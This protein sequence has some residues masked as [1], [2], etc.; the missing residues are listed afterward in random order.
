MIIQNILPVISDWKTFEAFLKGSYT[1]CI[2]MDF[3][4]NFMEDLVKQLH[5]HNKKGIV[6]MDL[7]HGIANDQYGT[8]YM[9]QKVHADG[10]ISTKPKAIEAAKSNQ[11]ISILRIFMID[12]R[13]FMRSVH[14]ASA[15]QPDY[16]EVL[17][18]LL[19]GIVKKL[20]AY[21]DIPVIGGGM[22]EN[23]EDIAKCLSGGM[24]AVSTSHREL[25]ESVEK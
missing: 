8:R 12:S 19:P 14:M 11:C 10:I 6:H 22:I 1:W 25:W 23:Q 16:I 5:E 24:Q 3:H 17:P 4:M 20:H 9:C 21:C 7:I 18:A 2:L 13:S 15:L